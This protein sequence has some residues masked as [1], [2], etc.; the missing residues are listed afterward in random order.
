MDKR[1]TMER[2][3]ADLGHPRVSCGADRYMRDV[4]SGG[5]GYDFRRRV[6]REWS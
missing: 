6:R 5:S 2:V 1:Q 4:K 3:N